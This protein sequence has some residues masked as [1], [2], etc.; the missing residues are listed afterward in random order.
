[1]VQK[2]KQAFQLEGAILVLATYS[3]PET[4]TVL[5]APV[6]LPRREAALIP[7]KHPCHC[8][9]FSAQASSPGPSSHPPAPVCKP[10]MTPQRLVLSSSCGAGSLEKM[11]GKHLLCAVRCAGCLP[12]LFT[13]QNRLKKELGGHGSRD[14]L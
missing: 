14:C 3:C 13:P 4:R 6:A 1:M 5:G 12:A 2:H 10:H 7:P 8:P 9:C 11:R